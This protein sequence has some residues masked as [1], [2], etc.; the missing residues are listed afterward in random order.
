MAVPQ[1]QAAYRQALSQNQTVEAEA[2][3]AEL[4]E[5][6]GR[7]NR[8][9]EVRYLYEQ[10]IL[11]NRLSYNAYGI[12]TT[13]ARLG[14]WHEDRGDIAGAIAAYQEGLIL[15]HHLGHRQGDFTWRIQRLRIQSGQVTVAPVPNHQ[16]GTLPRLPQIPTAWQGN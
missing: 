2:V 15:A 11:V 10:Q 7:A 14:E 8:W 9:Q 16:G 12:M 1:Y 13:F 4:T 3:V 5:L 6:Y